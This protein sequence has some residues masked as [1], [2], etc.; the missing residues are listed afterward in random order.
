MAVRWRVSFVSL[1]GDSY[2]VDI[3]DTLYSGS[4]VT[5]LTGAADAFS[6]SEEEDND[7]YKPIRGQSGYIRIVVNNS[8]EATHVRVLSNTDGLDRPV[9]LKKGNAICWAGFVSG[10]EYS[11]PWDTYPFTIEIPVISI[12]TA[13]KGVMFT[14]S[15]GFSSLFDLLSTVED[16]LPI[17]LDY[18]VPT[19][20]PLNTLLVPNAAF[21]QLLSIPERNDRSTSDV[22]ESTTLY[23][24][25]NEF[26]KYF[27]L[28]LHEYGPAIYFTA[29]SETSYSVYDYQGQA[30]RIYQTTY[31][32][33]NLVICSADN[34]EDFTKAYKRVVGTFQTQKDKLE[35]IFDI[36]SFVETFTQNSVDSQRMIF[37]NG[38]SEV[39][40]YRNGSQYVGQ[41]N[42]D[43]GG[44]IV[45]YRT[46]DQVNFNTFGGS[47]SDFFFVYS[48]KTGAAKA[49]AIKFYVPSKVYIISGEYSALNITCNVAAYYDTTQSG[50]FIK[51]LHMKIKIGNY[52]L[53]SEIPS[54]SDHTQYTW[55]TAESECWLVIDNGVA[56]M[57]NTITTSLDFRSA[58]YLDEISGFAI[59][60]PPL[61]AGYYSVYMELLANAEDEADF[62][63][64]SSIGYLVHGLQ[65]KI[66][67]GVN[68]PSGLVTSMNENKIIRLNTDE[69][70]DDYEVSSI[71]T[72]KQGV[73]Y[74]AGAVLTSSKGYES[75]RYEL[76]GM[77][78]VA[79]GMFR[80]RK[81]LTTDVRTVIRPIDTVVDNSNT[82]VLL[83]Q[84]V[85][86]WDDKSTLKVI[87][88]N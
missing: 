50:D 78:R 33:S 31:A 32:F 2:K 74:G 58:A 39:I 28:V 38:N 4:T 11:Q 57:E 81:V 65:L 29:H 37:F 71:L 24:C 82:Y 83:S 77:E 46:N 36:S 76:T 42:N 66:L 54:T 27:G 34:H 70:R 8:A 67:R 30:S 45:R 40:P 41:I 52:W 63:T 44:Q 62:G 87:N 85:D 6:T 73:Q 64:Y 21:H 59:D 47:W 18:I 43:S 20:I 22:Y 61:S 19:Y 56:T 80:P 35:K 26:C 68:N 86:W 60:M 72:T 5:S 10:E 69:F 17:G 3:Y 16:N 48:Q 23:D 53:K 1:L 15:D 51:R 7:L 13:M 55:T 88:K 79:T 75:T 49:T 9:V 84:S 25:I 14:Q 12:M